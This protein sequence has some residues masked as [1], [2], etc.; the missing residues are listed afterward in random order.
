MLENKRSVP[1]VALG[2]SDDLNRHSDPTCEATKSKY[3]NTQIHPCQAGCSPKAQ[4]ITLTEGEFAK[5]VLP[6]LLR[7]NKTMCKERGC[8]PTLED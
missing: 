3:S 1:V 5:P 6:R 2:V 7:R 8:G 4:I